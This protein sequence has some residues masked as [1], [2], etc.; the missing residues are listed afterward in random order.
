MEHWRKLR[1]LDGT[2]QPFDTRI[3]RVLSELVPKFRR[4]FPALN[5]E[6]VV[7]DVLE[8]AGRRIADREMR[9]GPIENLHGYA[10][11][12]LRS[13]AMSHMRCSSA[14]L[15]TATLEPK[16]SRAILSIVPSTIG[17][18]QRIEEDVLFREVLTHLTPEERLVFVW[19]KAGFSSK[20]IATRRGVSVGAIDTLSCRARQRIRKLL[21][22]H[23]SVRRGD[24]A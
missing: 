1:I 2:G 22:V 9:S 18:A 13:V 8:E 19:K 17:T 16:Q 21:G 15:A 10:W 6:I 23:E 3:E 20:E 24:S 14:R 5:D 11:V 4:Q 7:T 12:T